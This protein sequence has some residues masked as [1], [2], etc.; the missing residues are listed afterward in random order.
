MNNKQPIIY[1][2]LISIGIYIGNINNK[3]KDSIDNKINNILQITKEHYVDTLNY[4]EFEEDAINTILN[5]LDPHSSYIST[6]NFKNIK[7]DMQGAF[8]GIGVEFN[9]IEDTLVVIS[10]ISGGPSEKLGIKSGDRIIKI[11]KENVA[12]V[13]IKNQDIIDRLRGTKGSSVSISIKR[14]NQNNLIPF[15]II[16][17]DIPLHSIDAGI[18]LTNDIGYIKI[19][20]FAATTYKEM[21]K[22]AKKLVLQGMNNLILDL[23]SNPGGYLHIANQICDEFLEAGNLIVFTKGRNRNKKE[24]YATQE[25]SLEDINI[26]VLINEGSASASEIVAGALQDNDRGLIIGR[27]SFGK[28]LVQE[29]ISLH[30]G[31]VIRLTTQRYYTPSG[32]SIQTKY[33]NKHLKNELK[34]NANNNNESLK[35]TTKNGRTVYAEGG[36]NPDIIISLDTSLNYFEINKLI[37][38]G[39]INKFCLETGELLKKENISKYT[40]INMTKIYKDFIK[41]LGTQGG[42]NIE[43]GLSESIYLQNLLLANISRHLWGNDIYYKILSSEDDFIQKAISEF[44]TKIFF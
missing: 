20:R 22:K 43:I 30:D 16:R 40:Q 38:T 32:R 37:Y 6:K 18:M 34:I 36:I 15:K 24:I 42:P 27:R 41:Y 11:E 26:I 28:G 8:S 25:G 33:N 21:I 1:A 44:E 31:S 9:I 5:Q 23:R 4:A 35:Y 14:R 19:N 12:G 7:E 10:P 3:Q 17:D 29:Q 39:L 2:I 13:G